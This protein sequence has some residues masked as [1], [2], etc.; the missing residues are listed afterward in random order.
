MDRDNYRK[1]RN[2]GLWLGGGVLGSVLC[3]IC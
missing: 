3:G 1:N 2:F